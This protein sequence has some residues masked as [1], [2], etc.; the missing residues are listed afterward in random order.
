LEK[1]TFQLVTWK[2]W[3]QNH[4]NTQVLSQNTG[5]SNEYDPD[6]LSDYYESDSLPFPV[7]KTNSLFPPKERVIGVLANGVARAYP[8]ELIEPNVTRIVDTLAGKQIVIE[9]PNSN[10]AILKT[11]EGATA[12]HCLWFAWYAFNPETQIYNGL[13]FDLEKWKKARASEE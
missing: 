6:F 2:I 9:R 7:N 5:Y 11:Q 8:I 1:I 12:I 4:P 3:K 10:Q 13:G